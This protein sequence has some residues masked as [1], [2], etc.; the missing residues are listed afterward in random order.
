MISYEDFKKLEIRIATIDSAEKVENTDK[1]IKLTV[2]LGGQK[3]QLVA[4]IAENHNCQ[5]LIGKQVPVLT[6][7]EPKE[8][9]GITSHGMILA[10][11]SNGN[12]ILMHPEEKVAEGSIIR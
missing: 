1:L 2:D 6:N 11:E 8:I 3:R 7:L 4:G 10:I 12:A 9:R 5:D